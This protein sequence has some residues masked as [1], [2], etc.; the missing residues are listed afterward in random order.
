M[1]TEVRSLALNLRVGLALTKDTKSF[2]AV[3][4]ADAD[5]DVMFF[6][7]L[8]TCVEEPRFGSLESFWSLLGDVHRLSRRRKGVWASMQQ[9][10]RVGETTA[11][12]F[13]QTRQVCFDANAM[14][15]NTAQQFLNGSE[16]C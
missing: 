1:S 10:G 3:M 5:V 6:R 16:L 8:F 7:T 11:T 14:K 15:T 13:Y 4:D 12:Q 2:A 9:I